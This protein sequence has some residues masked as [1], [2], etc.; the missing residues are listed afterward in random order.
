MRLSSLALVIPG[1]FALGACWASAAAG[2]PQTWKFNAGSSPR[3]RVENIAGTIKVQPSTDGAVSVEATKRGGDLAEQNK[4]VVEARTDG[5]GVQVRVCCGPCAERDHQDCHKVE[6]DFVIRTP[7]SSRLSLNGVS[8]DVFASGIAGDHEISTVSGD[9]T[10]SGAR[11]LKLNTVSGD[12]KVDNAT[13]LNLTTVSGD[14]KASGVLGETHFHSVSGDAEW[15]GVCGPGC[16]IDAET[17][18][19]DLRVAVGPSA[20]FDLDYQSRSGDF[21]DDIGTTVSDRENHPNHVRARAGKGE[22]RIEF[23]SVSGDLALSK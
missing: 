16:R 4:V 2:P 17:T 10:V 8:T 19:G 12:A 7:G 6:V 15:R 9:V 1:F 23:Q 11:A 14:L 21:Q 20:S 13:S 5:Q 18:S 3:V 22:G